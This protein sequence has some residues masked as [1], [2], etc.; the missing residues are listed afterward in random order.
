[1]TLLT[2][3][4]ALA[5]LAAV[6]PAVAVVIGQRRVAEV[7]AL[8]GLAPPG[9]RAS[10][11][12]LAAATAGIALLGLAAAQPALTRGAASSVRR[13]VESLFVV[14]ISRSMAAS[15]TADSPTRLDRAT[16]AAIELR[17]SIPT[18][19]S[20]IA[21]LT[22][23]VLPDLLPVADIDAFDAVAQRSVQIESP[24]PTSTSVRATS[25]SALSDIPVGNYFSP[26]TK[27]RIVVLLTDGESNPVDVGAVASGFGASGLYRFVGI[28]VWGA[29]E[30]VYD[31][32]GDA[33]RAYRPDP[34]S[35]AVLDDVASSLGGRSF[36]VSSLGRAT[37]YLRRLV[38]T[39]PTA[40]STTRTHTTTPLTPYLAALAL[41]LVLAAVLPARSFARPRL[42]AASPEG[43]RFSRR[44]ARSGPARRRSPARS[45][46]RRRGRSRP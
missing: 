38:G 30:R 23:R 26:G 45:R 12:R 21:T 35:G 33:E 44:A 43:I 36:D 9:R 18:V 37:A 7:R 15:R 8:L 31:P 11:K 25:F 40:P 4:A 22:D 42:R 3:F 32:D 1:M 13:D 17:A 19:S 20:G 39:G 34:S 41:L 27:K 16:K 28:H 46:S 6:A 10:L 14:D 5:V 24:S 2:P 29:D